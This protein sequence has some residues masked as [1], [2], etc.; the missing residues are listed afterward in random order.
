MVAIGPRRP[1]AHL[2]GK[3]NLRHAIQNGQDRLST[4]IY[5]VKY[6]SLKPFCKWVVYDS[7]LFFFFYLVAGSPPLITSISVTAQLMWVNSPAGLAQVPASKF[8]LASTFLFVSTLICWLDLDVAN[9]GG[10]SRCLII[11]THVKCQRVGGY[12][13]LGLIVLTSTG[14]TS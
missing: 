4:S 13:V 7:G 9:F 12:K 6:S 5:S 1:N 2:N 8:S 11:R 10:T 14:H 3:T